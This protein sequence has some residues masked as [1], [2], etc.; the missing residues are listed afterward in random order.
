MG[1]SIIGYALSISAVAALL[2]GCSGA[3]PPIDAPGA[4]KG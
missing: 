1:P 4:V 3:Q 2:A